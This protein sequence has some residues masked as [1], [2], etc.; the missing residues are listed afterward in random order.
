MIRAVVDP[1][2]W[3][4]AL[5][6]PIGTPAAILAA[7]VRN[8]IA[9]IASPRLLKELATVLARPKLRRWCTQV[10]ADSFIT[11]LAHQ[12]E[13]HPDIAYPPA[14]TRDPKDDYLVALAHAHSAQ[15]VS[16]D[17]D[18]L[19]APLRPPAL[20]PRQLLDQLAR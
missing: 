13:L 20:S 9:V 7:L 19:D 18:I 15:L 11:Q 6:S 17:K 5:I 14:H 4:S 10:Q 3:V 2:V 1:G 16:G 12:A 8:E